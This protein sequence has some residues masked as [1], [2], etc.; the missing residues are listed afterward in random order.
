MMNDI[1]AELAKL[2]E[3]TGADFS[4]QVEFIAQMRVF[5][6]IENEIDIYSAG[7]EHDIDY[8]NQ[9]R[10]AH[11][12]LKYGYRVFLL[13]NPKNGRTPGINRAM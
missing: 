11:K 4:R 10:A 6:L 3:L 13:P 12:L 8:N 9:I 7:S 5:H 1:A 2:H